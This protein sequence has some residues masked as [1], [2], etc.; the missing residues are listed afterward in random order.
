MLLVR[1]LAIAAVLALAFEDLV[2]LEIDV[3]PLGHETIVWRRRPATNEM[4]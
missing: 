1:G 2:E 4:E 3:G